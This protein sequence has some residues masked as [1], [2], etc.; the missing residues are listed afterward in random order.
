MRQT[1]PRGRGHATPARSPD[2]SGNEAALPI[3]GRAV[4]GSIAGVGPGSEPVAELAAVVLRGDALGAGFAAGGDVRA[5]EHGAAVA[6]VLGVP[7]ERPAAE[8]RL[9]A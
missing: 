1:W 8:R 5:A 7:A 2:R 9:G 3:E 4:R 6:V